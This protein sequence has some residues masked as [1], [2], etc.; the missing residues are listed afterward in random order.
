MAPRDERCVEETDQGLAR[1][2]LARHDR[3]AL[4]EA[5]VTGTGDLRGPAYLI[6]VAGPNLRWKAT[7]KGVAACALHA[8]VVAAQLGV[9]SMAIPL[10][11]AGT[12][13]LS[14]HDSR[15]AIAKAL[16]ELLT[17]TAGVDAVMDVLVLTPQ[18]ITR[19]QVRSTS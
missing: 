9:T 13:G 19:S 3:M 8:V 12:G 7:P 18:R 15:A 11:G 16:D 6:H 14:A 5:V 10:I 1:R 17:T 4:D 2:E